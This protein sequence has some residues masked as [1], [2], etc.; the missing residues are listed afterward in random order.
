MRAA[1]HQLEQILCDCAVLGLAL[2]LNA[3]RHAAVER[4]AAVGLDG[5]LIAAASQCHFEG[6]LREKFILRER[7]AASA[8]TDRKRHAAP[9]PDLDLA[10]LIQHRKVCALHLQTVPRL[11]HDQHAVVV[12]V[13]EH[14]LGALQHPVKQRFQRG[15]RR[16]A[17]TL[18]R[19]AEQILII[20]HKDH[21]HTRSGVHIELTQLDVIRNILKAEQ[22]RVAV[23]ALI[24]GA[25]HAVAALT[26]DGF[27][28]SAVP[29]RIRPQR[30]HRMELQAEQLCP[31]G[32]PVRKFRVV[33]YD[34]ALHIDDCHRHR[35]LIRRGLQ[36]A[37][38]CG[39]HSCDIAQRILPHPD[40]LKNHPDKSGREQD[41]GKPEEDA[42]ILRTRHDDRDQ[43]A[44]RHQR[45]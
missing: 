23:F 28:G 13:A 10:R 31:A 25:A 29:D 19:S 12:H 43:T 42:V 21:Q 18:P 20:I 14:A 44:Q 9:A 17:F 15:Q 36:R 39:I 16:C 22:D 1:Q 35:H 8:D 40:D 7:L 2:V 11:G 3:L 32:N 33:P 37:C 5:S 26:D 24:I 34:L 45:A 4:K 6:L 38:Q 27:N 41:H 30:N